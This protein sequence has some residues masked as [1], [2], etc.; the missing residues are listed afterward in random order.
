MIG[1]VAAFVAATVLTRFSGSKIAACDVFQLD[2]DGIAGAGQVLP[3][4]GLE[5]GIPLFE[6]S[7]VEAGESV[8]MRGA[9]SGL[10]D[11]QIEVSLEDP[12][13][14]PISGIV[15][16]MKMDDDSG[17]ALR[18]QAYSVSTS[19]RQPNQ[20]SKSRPS[21]HVNWS[22][23]GDLPPLSQGVLSRRGI[24]FYARGTNWSA[25]TQP[26]KPRWPSRRR[27]LSSRL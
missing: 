14:A 1:A 21:V 18:I 16:I 4:L 12:S 2:R 25:W 19:V 22:K 26:S 17:Q 6:S 24:F 7:E 27:R 23:A 13:I 3:A 5:P 9:P 15:R 20:T 8:K 11:N 10:S